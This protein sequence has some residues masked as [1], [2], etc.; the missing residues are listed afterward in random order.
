MNGSSAKGGK[1]SRGGHI[2]RSKRASRK[3]KESKAEY[4]Q[5]KRGKSSAKA[6]GTNGQEA[7][8]APN[9]N[10]SKGNPKGRK[11]SK[12]RH[13]GEA[14]FK[15]LTDALQGQQGEIDAQ[16]EI[17]E[18][19]LVGQEADASATSTTSSTATASVGASITIGGGPNQPVVAITT[20]TTTPAPAGPP[21]PPVAPP[22]PPVV[23]LSDLQRDARTRFSEQ[24]PDELD[25]GQDFADK[26][27][28]VNWR[29]WKF[30]FTT[31]AEQTFVPYWVYLAISYSYILFGVTMMVYDS[32]ATFAGWFAAK[33]MSL[34]LSYYLSQSL[35]EYRVGPA[36]LV[37]TLVINTIFGGLC[38]N[39]LG[40]NS[41]ALPMWFSLAYWAVVVVLHFLGLNVYPLLPLQTK[42]T[43]R[44]SADGIDPRVH[45]DGR[46]D[47]MSLGKLEHTRPLTARMLYT[48]SGITFGRH[49]GAFYF[50]GFYKPKKLDVSL[51]QF[52]QLVNP[53]IL[54]HG[55]S[56]EENAR[57]LNRQASALHSVNS[58]RYNHLR[59]KD[60]NGNTVLLAFGY[61]QHIKQKMK[62]C[63][64]YRAP[65]SK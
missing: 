4:T 37:V 54:L 62:D 49:D 25:Y 42:H 36:G 23:T 22:P 46:Y 58:D 38:T 3:Y 29:G 55:S 2:A 13:Q 48:R 52:V 16:K 65:L 31:D 26:I 17:I 53:R 40:T 12:T 50:F 1:I 43:Y 11:H 24:V 41:L 8:K 28:L 14:V 61:L 64:F 30:S 34:F 18:D 47:V 35:K 60:L 63:P 56:E 27:E 15:A 20:T 9:N 59:N 45:H 7:R 57:H 51:E 5:S 19:L 32:W 6:E 39:L 33:T 21:G 44:L 10:K